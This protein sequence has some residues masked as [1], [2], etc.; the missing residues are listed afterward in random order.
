MC[1]LILSVIT[2]ILWRGLEQ[3][4][5]GKLQAQLFLHHNRLEQRLHIQTPPLE[6]KTHPRS[7]GALYLFLVEN[8]GLSLGEADFHPGLLTLSANC[9][10]ACY[11][12]LLEEANRFT[13]PICHSTGPPEPFPC[14][15]G[16]CSSLE[17]YY[18]PEAF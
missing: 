12:S 18:C 17:P 11:R 8:H 10:S 6:P 13:I 15:S 7:G 4:W 1:K 3:K 9:S 16:S 14:L 5:T 2:L